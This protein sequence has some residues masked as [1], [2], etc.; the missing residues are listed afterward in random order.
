MKPRLA[1]LGQRLQH[2]LVGERPQLLRRVLFVK[3]SHEVAHPEDGGG[4]ANLADVGAGKA[5][6]EGGESDVVEAVVDRLHRLEKQ[7]L[8]Q[9]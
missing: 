8:F 2:V 3:G 1:Q 9:G 6:G 5:V 7:R 4:P